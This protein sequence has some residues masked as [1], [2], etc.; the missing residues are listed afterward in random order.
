MDKQPGTPSLEDHESKQSSRESEVT[1]LEFFNN[2]EDNTCS[3]GRALTQEDIES[4]EEEINEIRWIPSIPTDNPWFPFSSRHDFRLTDWFS[5]S[6]CSKQSIDDYFKD[7]DLAIST[8]D[9]DRSMRSYADMNRALYSIPY[10]IPEGDE[11]LKHDLEI[12]SQLKGGRPEKLTLLSRPIK[13]CLEFLLGHL[14]FAPDLAWAPVRK[15]FGIDGPRVYDEMYTGDWWWNTQSRLPPGATVVPVI[16]ASDKTLMT[17]LRGDRTAWPVY[18]QIG[19]L[20]RRT[21]RKQIIPSTLLVGLLPISKEVSRQTDQ[22]LSHKIKSD[23]YHTA[24][25]IIFDRM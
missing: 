4:L 12:P 9:L 2:Q 11:W 23:L 14:P 18:I 17:K 16:I 1:V 22:D 10:G 7:P 25:G 13:Q 20:N 15:S 5:K 19:N 21:R 24:M 3:A 8:S 6:K